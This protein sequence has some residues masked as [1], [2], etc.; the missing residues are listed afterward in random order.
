MAAKTNRGKDFPGAVGHN[1]P[2][3]PIGSPCFENPPVRYHELLAY[4][5]VGVSCGR[6]FR[7]QTDAKIIAENV[8]CLDGAQ[9]CPIRPKR[10]SSANTRKIAVAKP[11][12]A[13]LPSRKISGLSSRISGQAWLGTL[14]HAFINRLLEMADVALWA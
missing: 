4:I 7:E 3:D 13:A 12:D 14:R 2:E 1:Y 5:N 9:S 8:W 10:K 6:I 11:S